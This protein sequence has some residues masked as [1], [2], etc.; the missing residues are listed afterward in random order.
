MERLNWSGFSARGGGGASGQFDWEVVGL[1]GSGGAEL[2]R[3]GSWVE[4]W[5]LVVETV[6]WLVFAIGIPPT[7]GAA[8]PE[9]RARE[10]RNRVA[11]MLAEHCLDCH[12][13]AEPDAGLTLDHFD[14]PID[15]LKGRS[16]WQKAVMKIQLK[17][18]PPPDA[19]DLSDEDRD[20]LADWITSVINEFDCGRAPNPG[21]V[22]LRRLNANEYQNTIRDLFGLPGF[23]TASTFPGDDVGYGFDNIGDTLTLPPL[24]MEKYFLEAERITKTLI[25]TPPPGRVF[26]AEYA[27]GQLQSKAN[28]GRPNRE[29]T[30]AS[31]GVATFREQIPWSGIFRLSVTASGDQAGGEPCMMAVLVDGKA[32]RKIRVPNARDEPRDFELSLRLRAGSREIGLA[33]LNDFYE[34]G[35]GGKEKQDRNLVLHHV[36]LSGEQPNRQRL[37]DSELSSYHRQIIFTTPRDDG[38]WPRATREILNRWASRAF[39]R[40]VD[41]E[42]LERYVRLAAEVQEDGGSFEE[43]IQVALQ[44]VLISPKFLFRVEPPA[45]N[46]ALAGYRDL[47]EFELATRLSYFL[48]SSMPDDVLFSLAVQQRLRAEGE[49][50]RQI[51]RMVQ[52][53]RASQ[54][55]QN[56]AGQW[57]TLRGLEKFH[58]DPQRFPQWN[59]RIRLLAEYET[60]RFF[61]EVMRRDMSVLRLLD[62]DFT[63]LNQELAEFYGIAGVEGPEFRRVSLRG[64]PRGGVL[65]QASVLAVTSNPTRTSPVKRGKWILD[66]LLAMPPP[67]PPPGVPEL[68]EKGK[69]RGSLRE[70]LQQHRADPACA[71]CHELMDPLG[72][73]LENFDAIG[74][75]RTVDEGLPIDPSGVMPD[76]TKI[77]GGTQLRQHLLSRH[78][79]AFVRCLAEKMLT[80]A[81][82]RGLEYYDK[83]AVDQIVARMEQQDYKFSALLS[84]IVL[85]D[86]FQKKGER[87]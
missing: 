50:E 33:F 30:L 60:L 26:V 59:D 32:I 29:L 37:A 66:N 10:L 28:A 35:G 64:T 27:G 3:G 13:G 57:L 62:A 72:F 24:L 2:G 40:P 54:F 17:Q 48:W 14:R 22:T 9:V 49:L 85:S 8:D 83:C 38:D 77:T 16:I 7:V 68:P 18:M 51:A 1:A 23:K 19:S 44:A 84:G 69:L 39:R 46:S 20:F 41:Q 43:S 47:D 87:E 42:D 5:R 53:R 67:M 31:V 71:N 73:A 11:P 81:L 36:R 6:P 45:G 55:I 25:Q 56:F 78:R 21:H 79:D 70:R 76:G 75:Y 61:A 12:S 52:D 65:T 80:Y 15:F 4:R 58:P 74:L 86:P 34:P 82:G 63:F